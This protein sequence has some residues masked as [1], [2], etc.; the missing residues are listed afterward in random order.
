[1]L[2]LKRLNIM[3]TIKSIE[4]KIPDITNLPTKTT[5]NAKINEIKGEISSINNL[6]NTTALTAVKIKYLVSG[7]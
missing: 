6:D 1:M 4:D 7:I 5:F 2:L 3:P